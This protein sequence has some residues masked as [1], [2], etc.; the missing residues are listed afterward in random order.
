MSSTEIYV[1]RK[2]G[3]AEK[4][5][6]VHN[7]WR[8]AYT[9]WTMLEKKYLQ[10]HRPAYDPDLK[11]A[12]RGYW[13]RFDYVSYNEEDRQK[14]LKEV[15]DLAKEGSP[16]TENERIV[17]I[18]TMDWM[19]CEIEDLPELIKAYRTFEGDTSLPEQANILEKILNEK[20][21]IAIGINQTS[22]AAGWDERG[23]EQDPENP[24]ENLPYNILKE[25]KHFY[26]FEEDE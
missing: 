23:D 11:H 21:V 4:Y 7:S 19:I 26:L 15:W 9:I 18:S 3:Y 6:N 14:A 13:S 10:S 25:N 5:A 16:L 17:F 22:V 24:E 20:D 8:G 1:F 2:D 12:P